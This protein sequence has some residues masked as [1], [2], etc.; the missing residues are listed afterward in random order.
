MWPRARAQLIRCD[1][2]IGTATWAAAVVRAA[3]ATAPE[4]AR[5][6]LEVHTVAGGNHFVRPLSTLTSS[7][8]VIHMGLTRSVVAS[9]TRSTRKT[10]RSSR[11][12]SL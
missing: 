3:P 6:T 7:R 1:M 12:C 10:R 8:G 11:G 9:L 4:D 5:R 2:T